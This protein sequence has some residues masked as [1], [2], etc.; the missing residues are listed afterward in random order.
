MQTVGTGPM[1]LGFF[2]FV[3]FVFAID[4]FIVNN[5]SH[6]IPPREALVWTLVWAFCA[7][8][9]DLALWWHLLISQGAQLAHQKAL[10]FLTAYIIEQSLS[11]DN[12]FVFILI[13]SYFAVPKQYQRRVL[14]YGV[15]GAIVF[16]FIMILSG[17]WLVSHFHWILYL[18]GLFLVVTG[19]KMFFA[20]EEGRDLLNNRIFRWL[21]RH[22]RVTPEYHNGNFFIKINRVW[23]ATPLLLVVIMIELTDI[24]FAFDSIPAAFSVTYD[25]FIVFTSNIFAVMGLRAMYFLLAHSAARFYLLKYGI[26]IVLTFVGLKMLVAHWVEIP[27]LMSLV[28]VVTILATSILLSSLKRSKE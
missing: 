13:F 12:L 24:I 26:A 17:T 1:W 8:L 14:L 16:R 23:H 2:I 28:V 18:F 7:I 21:H 9:F 27:I 5:K 19:I 20:S 6:E 22:L 3:I 11:V 25:P 4:L 15:V 10:E